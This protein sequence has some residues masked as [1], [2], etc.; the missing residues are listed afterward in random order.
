MFKIIRSIKEWFIQ[1]I[2]TYVWEV[3]FVMIPPYA[4]YLASITDAIKPWLPF[5]YFIVVV[6]TTISILSI[7]YLINKSSGVI[8]E[9]I[10]ITDIVPQL[11]KHNDKNL[12]LLRMNIF[13]A[14]SEVIIGN[15]TKGS[16]VVNSATN[17][18]PEYPKNM[19]LLPYAPLPIGVY[20]LPF[21]L[22]ENEELKIKENELDINVEISLTYYSIKNKKTVYNTKLYKYKAKYEVKEDKICNK[23]SENHTFLQFD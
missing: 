9:N 20:S 22:D 5:G 10:F 7:K 21:S 8:N 6:V 2:C 16:L 15:F 19:L 3:L 23:I 13:N 18:E 1:R 11:F 17:A 14:S 4:S 12:V